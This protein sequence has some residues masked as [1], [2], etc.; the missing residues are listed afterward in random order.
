MSISVQDPPTSKAR[1]PRKL[2]AIAIAGAMGLGGYGV[3]ATTLSISSAGAFSAGAQTQASGC[4]TTVITTPTVA[5]VPV[6][7]LFPMSSVVVSE[8]DGWPDPD[9]TA[10]WTGGTPNVLMNPEPAGPC[11]GK[12]MTVSALGA[13]DAVLATTA[14]TVDATTETVNLSGIPDANAVIKFAI[15]IK[16]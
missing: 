5:T 16:D 6:N 9:G 10:Y 4:D 2:A 3:Y 8:I 12:T 7:A 14:V 11:Y 15:I 1:R 13:G